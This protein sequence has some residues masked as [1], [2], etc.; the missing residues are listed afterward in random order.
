MPFDARRY[1][2]RSTRQPAF[3]YASPAAYFVKIC[4]H[5]RACLFGEVRDGVMEENVLGRI[6]R[7]RWHALMRGRFRVHLDAFVVMPNHVHGILVIPP[8]GARRGEASSTC[9]TS[10]EDAPRSPG[11]T[12]G[13]GRLD[14]SPLPPDAP[15]PSAGGTARGSLGALVQSFKSTSTRQINHRRQTPGVPVWQRNYYDRVLRNAREWYA[16]RRYIA[17]NPANWPHD[18]LHTPP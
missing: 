1:H 9:G 14:A 17:A 6:V 10:K 12:V 3:D 5:D 15:P 13:G 8:R 11:T 2:R 4:T 16:C 7:S 18:R